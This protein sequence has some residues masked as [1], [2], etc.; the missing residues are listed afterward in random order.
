MKKILALALVTAAALSISVP[1]EAR[2]GCGP[3]WHRGPYGHCVRNV[4]APRV[5]VVVSTPAIGVYISGRGYWDGH[6]YWRHRGRHHGHWR[7]W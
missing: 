3:G 1:A 6:R 2:G 7:Y 5:G 4:V